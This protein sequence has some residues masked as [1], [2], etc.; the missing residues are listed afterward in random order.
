[1]PELPASHK[2]AHPAKLYRLKTGILAWNPM[3]NPWP[4]MLG[5]YLFTV[6]IMECKLEIRPP[7]RART[8]PLRRPPRDP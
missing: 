5:V 3:Q 2:H 1:M 4:A 7:L 8:F 6:K